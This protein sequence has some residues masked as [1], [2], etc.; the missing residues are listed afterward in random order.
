M[1]KVTVERQKIAPPS[2]RSHD[3]LP[4]QVQREKEQLS[5]TRLVF[6]L[7]HNAPPLVVD[8]QLVKVHFAKSDSAPRLG[9]VSFV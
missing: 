7:A 3:P 6:D 4:L 1:M 5:T 2:P 8:E 9:F